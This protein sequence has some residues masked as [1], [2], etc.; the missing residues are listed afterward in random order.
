MVQLADIQYHL[1]VFWLYT[2]LATRVN[3]LSA[4]GTSF[5]LYGMAWVIYTQTFQF[6][7]PSSFLTMCCAPTCLSF[8][9]TLHAHHPHQCIHKLYTWSTRVHAYPQLHAAH[10]VYSGMCG[11]LNFW[12]SLA[13]G[14][15]PILAI[16]WISLPQRGQ[17]RPWKFHS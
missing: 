12:V 5:A 9:S 10:L 14:K 6:F 8:I 11:N 7:I 17:L 1:Y 16:Y 15:T 13:Q 3:V 2:T 4:K